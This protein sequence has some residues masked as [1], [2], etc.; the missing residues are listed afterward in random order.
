MLDVRCWMFDAFF[1][2][3]FAS[4]RPA[5]RHFRALRGVIALARIWRAFIEHHRDVTSE[6]ALNFH[7]N[8]RRN[9]RRLSI[10]MIL[11]MHAL[12]SNF[13][14]FSE[15]KNLVPAAIG[16]NWSVPIHEF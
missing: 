16:Q 11:K 15:R 5:G 6:R 2:P 9:E 12:L 10:D 14:Q 4:S 1:S 3:S 8:L 13:A 7:R